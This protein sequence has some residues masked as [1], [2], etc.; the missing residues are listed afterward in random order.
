MIKILNFNPWSL[1]F[2]NEKLASEFVKENLEDYK[3]LYIPIIKTHCKD[4]ITINNGIIYVNQHPNQRAKM[5][6]QLPD[7]FLLNIRKRNSKILNASKQL[8]E[9]TKCK[10]ITGFIS[11]NVKEQNEALKNSVWRILRVHKITRLLLLTMENKFLVMYFVIKYLL[12]GAVLLVMYKFL[13]FFFLF[14]SNKKK[15]KQELP[16]TKAK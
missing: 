10:M 3:K 2:I 9:N 16:V 8:D 6:S 7:S 4:F 14:L 11:S 13:Y 1:R 12:K 15:G 5:Y